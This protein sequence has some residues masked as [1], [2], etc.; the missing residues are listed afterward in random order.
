ND[1]LTGSPGVDTFLWFPGDGSDTV[2]GGDGQDRIVFD[3]SDAAEKFDLSANG[4]WARVTHDL[5]GAR[6]DVGGVETIVIDPLG[7]ADTVTVNALTGTPVTEIGLNLVA[8][9]GSAAG[10]GAADSVIVNGRNAADFIPIR[11]NNEAIFVDRGTNV[12]VG[13]GLSYSLTITAAEG[14]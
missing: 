8:T 11:G 5:D 2:E 1:T 10:D 3:G 7:G 13:G 14:A 12:G 4:T 9:L 6:V